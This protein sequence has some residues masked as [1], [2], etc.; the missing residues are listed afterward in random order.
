MTGLCL[1]L[2]KLLS[3]KINILN[4]AQREEEAEQSLS[5]TL[6]FRPREAKESNTTAGVINPLLLL[7]W[8]LF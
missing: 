5:R 8:R 7:L 1:R 6:H 3:R 4:E 2:C